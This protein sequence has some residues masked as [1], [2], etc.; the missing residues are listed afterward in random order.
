MTPTMQKQIYKIYEVAVPKGHKNA[1]R[2]YLHP[3]PPMGLRTF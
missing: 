2:N 3:H 1:T